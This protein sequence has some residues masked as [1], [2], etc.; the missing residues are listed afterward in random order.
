MAN[1]KYVVVEA[2]WDMDAEPFCYVTKPSA[3]KKA[4]EEFDSRLMAHLG[5]SDD[6]N[7]VENYNSKYAKVDK[8]DD[9]IGRYLLCVKEI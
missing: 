9:Y 3:Y 7:G 5:Y 4:K 6:D 8:Y 1:K 2:G